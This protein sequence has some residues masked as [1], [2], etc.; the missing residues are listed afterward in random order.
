M[1]RVISPREGK[2]FLATSMI[3]SRGRTVFIG[4]VSVHERPDGEKIADIAEAIAD[5]ARQ[6]GHTPRVAVLS[7]TTFGNPDSTLRWSKARHRDSRSAQAQFR[8]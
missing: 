4:D 1:T 8:V 2:T 7:F 6:M 3:V 5:K